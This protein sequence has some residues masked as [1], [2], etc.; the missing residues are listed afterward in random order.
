[1]HSLLVC[2]IVKRCHSTTVIVD[3]PASTNI[4]GKDP[5]LQ[6]LDGHF[7][8]CL[9]FAQLHCLSRQTYK[10]TRQLILRN[11]DSIRRSKTSFLRTVKSNALQIT[12]IVARIGRGTRVPALQLVSAMREVLRTLDEDD[13]PA[14]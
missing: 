14:T 7:S 5:L 10:S 12:C 8:K 13:P 9:P 4:T 2:R 11:Q 3:K 1:M 6:C